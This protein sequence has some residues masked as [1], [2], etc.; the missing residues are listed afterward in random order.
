[1]NTRQDYKREDDVKPDP[2][3][4][5]YALIGQSNMA[6]RGAVGPED[7]ETHPRV[8]CLDRAQ[9][10]AP[11]ADP[12][13]FDKPIAGVGPGLAFGKAMA[14]QDPGVRI[15]LIPCAVGGSP[16]RTWQPGGYWEQ[17]KSHPYDDTLARC[18]VALRSG[19][20]KGFLWHQGESD[21]NAQDA[22]RYLDRL[23]TLVDRLR[24]VLQAP[25]AAFVVATLGDFFA[26]RNEWAAAINGALERLA[27]EVD[28][29]A[30]VQ[31]AGLAHGGD[32]LHFDAPS[33]RELGRRYAQAMI[34]LQGG[35]K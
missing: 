4:H 7:T 12:L 8:L 28:N 24:T 20:L 26:V 25:R 9:K 21:S 3:F 30:C 19:E 2:G 10:W 27:S 23:K 14:E 15:G 5:L 6:G 16:I 32:D 18:T 29:A 13:H 17:T 1:V 33:A 35:V 11:A 34:R 22:V 31:S